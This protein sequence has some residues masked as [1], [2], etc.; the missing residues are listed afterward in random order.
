MRTII[1]DEANKT[2]YSVHPRADKMYHDLHDMYWWPRM[3]RD[4]ATYVSKCLTCAKVKAEHQRP[5]SLL[6]QPEI[7][8]WKLT[9][10]A[11]FL[12]IRE[13]F[14]TEKLVRLNID[15][16]LARIRVPVSIIS[17]QEGSPIL[18]AK[19]GEG[20]RDHQKSYADNRRKPLEFKVGDKVLLKVSSWKGV[21][22]F[23]KKGKSALRYVGPFEILERIGLVVYR[24]RLPNELSEVHDTFHVSNLKKY[25]ADAN[26]HVPLEEIKVD[27]TLHFV[28]K[29]VEI[30]DR[31]IKTLKRSK[32]PIVKV[33]CN[34]K[35]GP[36]FTREREDHMKARY[37]QL[38]VANSGKS[39]G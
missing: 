27:K 15:E 8:E 9:K 7:P 39:S 26:L 33:R 1:M 21:M 38:F 3:K 11:H 19:I 6:Q 2:G 22:R 31:E 16:I 10:S 37:P 13:D 4:I 32:I 12:A 5:S 35:R 34:S 29:P 25:L 30:M 17:D 24:L 36:E 28:E 20:A 23:R 18:W 14:S